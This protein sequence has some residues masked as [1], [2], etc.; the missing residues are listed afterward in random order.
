VTLTTRIAHLQNHVA[1][2]L[3]LDI[4]VVFFGVRRTVPRIDREG[5]G[6]TGNLIERGEELVD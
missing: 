6:K 4:Q 5:S 3:A 2:Q 1:G